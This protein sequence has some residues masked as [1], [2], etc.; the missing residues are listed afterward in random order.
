MDYHKGRSFA[1]NYFIFLKKNCFSLRTSYKEWICYTNYTDVH[2]H[3]IG[4][5]KSFILRMLFPCEYSEVKIQIK[6][7]YRNYQKEQHF[8]F[9]LIDESPFSNIC[10]LW[11]V[12]IECI[13][14]SWWFCKHVK[15]VKRRQYSIL[16]NYFS[17][18]SK[19]QFFMWVSLSINL[20]KYLI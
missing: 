19:T 13:E 10:T 9:C 18:L 1:S 3:T 12:T 6:S 5:R 16:I 11:Y 20:A 14:L 7:S 4:E 15:E 8:I 2:I 17:E